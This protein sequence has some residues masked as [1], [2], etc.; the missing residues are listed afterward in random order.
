M[1]RRAIDVRASTR[2]TSAACWATSRAPIAMA[3][4]PA[5]AA[6]PAAR[7]LLYAFATAPS[8]HLTRAMIAHALWGAEY[9]PLATTARSR[10]ASA[11]FARC[12]PAS[13]RFTPAPPA[14]TSGY[15]R[16]RSS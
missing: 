10:A 7:Q 13:P 3:R 6:R 14:I 15:R 9:D 2:W 12:S 8:H 16:T 1:D 5:Y 11:G 4:S